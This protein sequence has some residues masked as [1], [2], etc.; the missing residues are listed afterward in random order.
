[1]TVTNT[2]PAPM[3]VQTDARTGPAKSTQ[4]APQFAG[5][6]LQLPQSVDDLSQLPAY[7]VPPDT[8][9]LSATASS[10]V[11]AQIELSNPGGGIDVF[12]D[13]QA[14]QQG[15]TI[16]TAS[17]S[18]D[19]VGLGEWGIYVQE[20]GP[21]GDGGAPA[22]TSMLSATA[23]TLPFD[24]AVTSSTGDP[25]VT[26]VDPTADPGAPVV[27]APGASATITV[28]VTPSGATGSRHSGVLNLVTT[29]LGIAGLFN[30]TGEVLAA[31]PYR[32]TIK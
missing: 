7:L 6:T 30:T 11:P 12:G 4:L 27:I 31:L 10:T 8:T 5:S 1:M 9:K 18:D 20:I 21:F 14:A 2:G 24:P 19:P 29:P 16:S 17:V 26:A 32:Y 22:A 15:S 25:F 3:L 23:V 13:L 28:K